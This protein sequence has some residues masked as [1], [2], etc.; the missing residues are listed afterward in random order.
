MSAQLKKLNDQ[1]KDLCGWHIIIKSNR[2]WM[3]SLPLHK[4]HSVIRSEIIF[5]LPFQEMGMGIAYRSKKWKDKNRIY[6][7]SLFLKIM[8]LQM[9]YS[10]DSFSKNYTVQNYFLKKSKHLRCTYSDLF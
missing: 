6:S 5:S 1:E 3:Q 9:N 2:I 10:Q 8:E 7:I 4:D